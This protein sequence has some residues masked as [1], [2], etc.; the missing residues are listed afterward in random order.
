[1]VHPTTTWEIKEL[2]FKPFSFFK[3]NLPQL[4]SENKHFFGAM[5]VKMTAVVAVLS[6]PDSFGKYYSLIAQQMPFKCPSNVI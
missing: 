4:L 2:F 3:V 6:E 5:T 1:M